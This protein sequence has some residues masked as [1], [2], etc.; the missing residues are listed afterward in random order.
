MRGAKDIGGGCRH[1]RSTRHVDIASSNP[2][3][4]DHSNTDMDT[5]GI[6]ARDNICGAIF[7]DIELVSNSLGDGLV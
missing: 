7:C 6:G 3:N 1:N 2:T 4:F 5:T